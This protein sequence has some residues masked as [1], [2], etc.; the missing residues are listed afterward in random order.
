MILSNIVQSLSAKSEVSAENND[1]G[2]W[3]AGYG[4]GFGASMM[5]QS[6]RI[7]PELAMSYATYF[8]CIRAIAQDLSVLPIKIVKKVNG[9]NVPV[10]DHPVTALFK[11]RVNAT[12]VASEFRRDMITD[13]LNYGYSYAKIH[14]SDDK[15]IGLQRYHPTTVQ[16]KYDAEHGSYYIVWTNGKAEAVLEEDMLRFSSYGGISLA[17]AAAG[18]VATGLSQDAMMHGYSKNAMIPSAIMKTARKLEKSKKEELEARFARINSGGPKAGK[19][20]VI[21]GDNDLIPWNITASDAQIIESS[22][23]SAEQV[24]R[25]CGVPARKVHIPGNAA[26]WSTLEM[27]ELEYQRNTLLPIEV[28]ME[29]NI[30]AKMLDTDG[31]EAKT[32]INALLRTDIAGRIKYYQTMIGL[33]ILTRNEVRAYEDLLPIDGGE[34]LL[35][36]VNMSPIDDDGN[37]KLTADN[38]SQNGAFKKIG[39][40]TNLLPVVQDAAIRSA[41]KMAKVL[42]TQ[43][44]SNDTKEDGEILKVCSNHYSAVLASTGT[45]PDAIATILQGMM[46]ARTDA[47]NATRTDDDLITVMEEI[48]SGPKDS[49]ISAAS[50]A[51]QI[52]ELI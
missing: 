4:A 48:V 9:V 23:W 22:N 50:E 6:K 8:A 13:A 36:P 17:Q 11:S 29:Q 19:M 45:K 5:V 49:A 18:Y 46:A 16:Y 44:K 20:I 28:M 51:K 39:G 42:S 33:G 32:M 26:G 37:E 12:E 43:P 21:D 2:F 7:N 10:P 14:R 41:R 25:V 40:K 27:T 34:D 31:E 15:I 38:T 47:A 1:P 3:Q 30:T 24:I 35:V 52:M